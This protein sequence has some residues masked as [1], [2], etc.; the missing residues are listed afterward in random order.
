MK[1]TIFKPLFYTALLLVV[2]FATVTTVKAASGYVDPNNKWAWGTNIGWINFSPTHGGVD[3]YDD[4]LE[5]Y[6]WSENV[7][8]IRLGTYT[9]GGSHTYANNTAT[10]YGVNQD[11]SGNLSGYAWGTNI[12]WINFAP[13]YG[14]VSIDPSTGEFD[15]Y[16]WAENVGWISFNGGS[17]ANT[18]VVQVTDTLQVTSNGLTANGKLLTDNGT[19]SGGFNQLS[20]IFNKALNNPAGNTDSDDA[21]NPANYLL[22]QRGDDNVFD[23]VDCATV[24]GVHADDVQ[25]PVDSVVYSS[26]SGNGPYVV[27]VNVNGG[28]KIPVG[29][30]RLLVCGTTSVVDLNGVPLA[31]DGVNSGTDLQRTF[32]VVEVP[33]ELPATGFA[34]GRITNLPAQPASVIY[35]DTDMLLEIPLLN[36]SASIIGVPQNTK[37]WDITWLGNR[38]GYLE[39]TAYPTWE[40]N[41]ILTGHATDATGNPGIFA[42]IKALKYG[43]KISIQAYGQ[44]YIYEVRENTRTYADDMRVINEHKSND[45][46]SLITC[47][48]YDETSGQYHYRR[49]VRAVLVEVK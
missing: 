43:D 33:S 49:V 23:T 48:D 14:G 16:A 12:G 36:V 46:L 40:G 35:A 6:I 3:V 30:Y 38:V 22:F 18:Y 31:G 45:W 44:D 11:A 29:E 26:G 9:G 8:W 28:T 10:N 2:A 41:T 47:E 13:T 39:G 20:I 37:A 42:N 27:T 34:V 15:G 5:G 7:G 25:I 17:G 24:P 21:T 4:H 19:L 32:N 1:K